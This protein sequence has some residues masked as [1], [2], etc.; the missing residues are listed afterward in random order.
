LDQDD[1]DVELV[2]SD[3]AN[4]DETPDVL[5]ARAGDARLKVIRQSRLL[6]VTE[7]WNA[8][9]AASSGDYMVLVGDDDLL[10]PGYFARL[11]QLLEE[12]GGPECLTYSCYAFVLPAAITGLARAHYAD[13]HFRIEPALLAARHLGPEARAGIVADMFRFRPRL[14]LNLQSTA[15]SRL[16]A[17]R[18]H[19][20]LFRAPFPDH[21]ALNGMLMTADSWACVPDQLLVIGVSPKSFGHYS[22]SGETARGLAYLDSDID[23]PGALP[24]NELLTA[25][26]RWLL[27]LQ[28]DFPQAAGLRISRG[29]YVVRQVWDWL[30]AWRMGSLSPRGCLENLALLHGEDWVLALGLLGDPEIRRAAA[31]RLRLR[32]DQRADHIWLGLR[33]APEEVTTMSDFAA[34]VGAASSG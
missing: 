15:F 26:Y 31:A 18:L 7:N 27:L 1:A 19:R 11:R 3:N 29:D 22:F 10:L 30:R 17:S 13:P 16:A 8:A 34:W 5:A 14:P 24:G 21:Y 4:T 32:G 12:C 9:Y 28:E 25:M 2:V 6:S 20:G 33:P 23:F